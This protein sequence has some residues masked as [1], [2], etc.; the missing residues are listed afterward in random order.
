MDIKDIKST[1]KELNPGGKEKSRLQIP[2]AQSR[3]YKDVQ[4]NESQVL[5]AR[6]KRADTWL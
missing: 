1:L 5:W 6:P 3:L 2:I 4:K